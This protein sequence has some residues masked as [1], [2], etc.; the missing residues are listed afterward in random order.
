MPHSQPVTSSLEQENLTLSPHQPHGKAKSGAALVVPS[1]QPLEVSHVLLVRVGS[2]ITPKT[3]AKE[4]KSRV[5]NQTKGQ[6]KQVTAEY[7]EKI[8]VPHQL[9]IVSR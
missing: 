9:E 4:H 6:T 1:T 8:Q 5:T 2:K 7:W 3:R